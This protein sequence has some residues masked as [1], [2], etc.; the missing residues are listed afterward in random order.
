MT[1]LR[2]IQALARPAWAAEPDASKTADGRF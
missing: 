2:T 1:K